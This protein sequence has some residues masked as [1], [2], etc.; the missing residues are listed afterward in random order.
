M[1]PLKGE[2]A[3]GDRGVKFMKDYEYTGYNKNLKENARNLRKSM[4][5]QDDIFGFVFLEIIRLNL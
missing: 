2:M 5:D 1:S 3:R 4:T